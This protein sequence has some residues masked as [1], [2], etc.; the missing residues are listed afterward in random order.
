MWLSLTLAVQGPRL[1]EM[2]RDLVV[3]LAEL[4]PAEGEFWQR[5]KWRPPGVY[6]RA[7][8]Q[9][10]V[11]FAQSSREGP[12]KVFV[13]PPSVGG[14]AWAGHTHE[15]IQESL[16]GPRFEVE[17]TKLAK[18]A[19]VRHLFAWVSGDSSTLSLASCS[20]CRRQR[21]PSLCRPRYRWCGQAPQ[22]PRA[23][24]CG[25]AVEA[26]GSDCSFPGSRAP[27]LGHA[28]GCESG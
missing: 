18:V 28:R 26:R 10:P 2:K 16:D 17:R 19:G 11:D 25:A 7:I 27:A 14:V 21:C 8:D 12:G 22:R 13:M 23:S 6:D 15:L 24:R 9:L 3:A 20:M 1:S 5:P 4:E